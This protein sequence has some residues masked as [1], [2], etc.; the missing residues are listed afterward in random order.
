MFKHYLKFISLGNENLYQISEPIGFDGATFVLEQ[1]PKRYGRDYQFGAISKL[2]F[3]DAY[4]IEVVEPFAINPQG[5]TS[6][7]LEYG[8]RWLLYINKKFGFESKVEYILEKDGVFFSNGMLDFTEK[9]LTDGYTYFSCKL[10]QNDIVADVKRRIDDKFNAFSNKDAKENTITPMP[11]FNYLKR[12]TPLAQTSLWKMPNARTTPAGSRINVNFAQ[13][14]IES[15]VQNSLVWLSDF[16]NNYENAKRDFK[17]LRA[18][19]DLSEVQI[20]LTNDIKIDYR[21]TGG[22][23]ESEVAMIL[24]YCIYEEPYEDFPEGI[25]VYTKS[26]FGTVNQIVSVDD[27]I[28]FTIPFIG[29]GQVLTLFW[30]LQ[31][32][33]EHLDEGNR[34]QFIFNKQDTQIKAISTAID[35]VIKASRWI[36]LIKQTSKFTGNLPVDANLFDV[37]GTHYKNVVFTSD[38]VLQKTTEFNAIPKDVFGSIEEV[39]CDYEIS[40]EKIYIG[41]QND[42]YENQEIAVLQMLPDVEASQEYNDRNMINKFRYSYKTFEQERTSLETSQSFH[43][44]TEWRFLNE[45]VEN[46]KE[47]K[48]DF[49]RDPFA[50]QQMINLKITQPN[51][52]TSQD[53]KIYIENYTEL[54]PSSFGTFGSRLLMRV[55]EGRVELLNIDSD[56]QTSGTDVVINWLTIG[57]EEGS[58]FE[59]VSGENVGTYMVSALTQSLITLLPIGFVPDF[60]GD[61]FIVVKYFYTN[62][63]YQTRTNQGFSLIDGL[64]NANKMPNLA[65]TIKRNMKYFYSYFATCLMY[66]K[67]DIVNAYFKNNGLLKTQLT[68]ETEPLIENAPILYSDLP[69]PIVNATIHSLNLYATFEDINNYLE[70]YKTTKGFI[71]CYDYNGKVIRLYAQKLEHTWIS[72]ELELRGE[73]QYST[74]FL[75]ID[76]TIGNLFVNDAPYN[77]SGVEDWWKFENDFI[78]L[79]DEKSRPLSTKYAF[80]FVVLNG[81]TYE[82]K[83]ELTNAL[84]L[85]NE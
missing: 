2:E 50:T 80:N 14:L 43:T 68:S 5:D 30:Y 35:Q 83:N 23:A 78:Q 66:A 71:R 10:I 76:G 3:V 24:T 62:V 84:L 15:G 55:F 51:T 6:N 21:I 28:N 37:N 61:A 47:I 9:G 12:A 52:S 69:I 39:N 54:A 33:I 27:E 59:I 65:Y 70:A 79:F 63:P 82:T 8:L 13:Q 7:R 32:D 48:N 20:K 36:D 60:D 41:H 56:G 31:W 34:T 45:Q 73:E 11:T 81:V 38:M 22:S 75:T 1:E 58:T 40:D 57:V 4:S 74:E 16:T 46:F 67:K 49:V 72:N 17:H 64:S 53:D 29:R 25:E 77:L 42:F 85:L 26:V 18:L 44:D 19:N